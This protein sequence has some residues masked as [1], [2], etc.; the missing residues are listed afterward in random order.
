MPDKAD[1][2]RQGY[3]SPQSPYWALKPL[4]ILALPPDHKFWQAE[5]LPY[6]KE[7]LEQPYHVC[8]SALQVYSQ[9][10]GHTFLLT[11]GQWVNVRRH[12]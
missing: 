11:A 7:L 8:Q 1:P 6:P 10:A 4:L 2:F 3:N 12:L 9:A 5:E